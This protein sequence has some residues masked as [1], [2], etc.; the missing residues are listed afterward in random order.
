MRVLFDQ[1]VPRK[2]RSFLKGRLRNQRLRLPSAIRR[3]KSWPNPVRRKLALIVLST[4]NWNIVK[5]H[6]ETVT[7][8]IDRGK[9]GCY[10]LVDLS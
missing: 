7:V 1:N 4:N 8:A 5:R 9:T 10:E 3:L 6:V 2:L